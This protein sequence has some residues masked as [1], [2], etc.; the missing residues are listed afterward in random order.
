MRTV[1]SNESI[2]QA[3]DGEVS[4]LANRNNA[5]LLHYGEGFGMFILR[6]TMGD[7]L[8]RGYAVHAFAFEQPKKLSTT[9]LS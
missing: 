1:T 7:I 4:N 3:S 9:A 8:S 6:A 2:P 5:V